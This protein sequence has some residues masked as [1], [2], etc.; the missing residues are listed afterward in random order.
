MTHPPVSCPSELDPWQQMPARLREIVQAAR[1]LLEQNGWEAV[2]MAQ[3]AGKLQIKA[4]SLYKHLTGKAA[5]R[6]HLTAVG[7]AEVG[8]RLHTAI[9][10]D[11]G[12]PA[13]LAA[14]RAAA[15]AAPELYRLATTGKLDRDGLPPGL[16]HWAGKPFLLATGDPFVAQALWSTAH[17][18]AI[19]EIDHRYPTTFAPE[20]TWQQAANAYTRNKT[21]PD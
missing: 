16:E 5:L 18:M 7:M 20:A 2:T 17:G 6:T 1:E 14:Y 21:Q 10:A 13:L 8:E 19:L 11:G 4:P 15:H 9:S 3:V 12:V